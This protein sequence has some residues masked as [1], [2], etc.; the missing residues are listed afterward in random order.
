MSKDY[1]DR[2]RIIVAQYPREELKALIA[3]YLQRIDELAEDK[4]KM[5]KHIIELSAKVKELEAENGRYEEA[6]KYVY[7][8]GL[9]SE[10]FPQGHC[11]CDVET[12]AFKRVKEALKEVGHNG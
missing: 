3:E 4:S 11:A 12:E 10:V 1:L 6:L 5:S 7:N 9:G 8:G 2:A